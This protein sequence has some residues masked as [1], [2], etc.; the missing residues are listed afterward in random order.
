MRGNQGA[1]GM[2]WWLPTNS[3]YQRGRS[4]SIAHVGCD[5]IVAAGI[6]PGSQPLRALS[7]GLH[8]T[9]RTERMLI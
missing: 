4:I 1:A 3:T 2:K 7:M 9:L 8:K 6:K 5:L